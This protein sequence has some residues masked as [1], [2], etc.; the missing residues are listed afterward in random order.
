M[1]QRNSFQTVFF[2]LF[3]NIVFF[4]SVSVQSLHQ[5][6][7]QGDTTDDSA[8]ILFQSFLH[9]AIVSSSSTGRD[10]QSLLFPSNISSAVHSVAHPPMWR[11][12]RGMWHA[13]IKQVS[14][15]WQL[16]EE[17]PMDLRGSWS[18][19]APIHPSSISLLS[20]VLPTLQGTLKDGFGEAVIA[21]DMPKPCKFLSL[22]GCQKRFQWTHE[23]VDFVPHPVVGLDLF[24]LPS[25]WF[26]H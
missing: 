5:L 23:A 19:S 11:S 18:C 7:G 8:D 13:R 12:C 25:K 17:V 9:K 21:R 4:S 1:R 20:T 15:S 2:F 22:D 16:P 3:W 24:M 10:V 6:G 14:V 26:A